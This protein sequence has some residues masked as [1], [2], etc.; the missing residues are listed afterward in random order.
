MKSSTRQKGFTLIEIMVVVVILGVLAAMVAPK[1]LS[2]PDQAKVTVAS[3]DI[4]TIAQALELF[5]LDN[6]FYP[7]TDQG[8]EALSSRPSLTPEA[9]NWNQEGYLKKT[10]QDPWGND[11]IYLQP[12][13]HGR[14]DL[15]SMGSDGREGGD[16]LARDITNWVEGS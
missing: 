1:I 15:Y 12:G 13:N 8:L 2:R 11:Y 6:G 14:F 7:T 3:S 16:E 9:K 10:P 4:E 5:R